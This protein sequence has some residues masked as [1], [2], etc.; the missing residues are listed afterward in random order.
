MEGRRDTRRRA[1][2]E[3]PCT[4]PHTIQQPRTVKPLQV[5]ATLPGMQP[6]LTFPHRREP[7]Q[8]HFGTCQKLWRSS[9]LQ[10]RRQGWICYFWHQNKANMSVFTH[11]IDAP[12]D[13]EHLRSFEDLCLQPGP[14]PG[15]GLSILHSLVNHLEA[16]RRCTCPHINVIKHLTFV[17]SCAPTRP[18][19]T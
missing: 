8:S 18:P 16:P 15:H 2:F 6:R 5:A 11:I 7:L 17:R 1:R 10:R 4:C 12:T 19:P 3:A 13:R 9:G 14:E